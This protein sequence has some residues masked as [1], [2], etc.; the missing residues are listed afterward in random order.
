VT[1]LV[2][3]TGTD[4]GVGKTLFT[5]GLL[6]HL[7]ASGVRAVAL[8]PFSSGSRADARLFQLIQ[9]RSP[10]LEVIN[11]FHFS[12]PLAPR[13]ASELEGRS[14]TLPMALEAIDRAATGADVV[15][16]EGAGGLFVPLGPDFAISDLMVALKP[17][18]VVAVA[19]NKLGAIN[20]SALTVRGLRGLGF[21]CPKL[22]LMETK[23][24][25]AAAAFNGSAIQRLLGPVLTVSLPYAG[26]RPKSRPG[27]AR[28]SALCRTEFQELGF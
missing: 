4:T 7:R 1:R 13:I 15:L 10:A 22:V 21:T 9:G 28:W 24:P 5:A 2:F 20:L 3:I 19:Q 16:V 23:R 25:D 12:Q 18:D 26:A 14:V 11:P 8:K 17:S 6:H 27:V